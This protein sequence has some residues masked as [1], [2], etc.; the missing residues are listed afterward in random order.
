[1]DTFWPSTLLLHKNTIWCLS[2]SSCIHLFITTLLVITPATQETKG[3]A[4]MAVGLKLVEVVVVVLVVVV[5]EVEKLNNTSSFTKGC[6]VHQGSLL[7]FQHLHLRT[8]PSGWLSKWN[9][10]LWIQRMFQ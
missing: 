1:M 7:T 8:P 5:V 2:L 9:Q 4:M 6:V 3:E 10:S